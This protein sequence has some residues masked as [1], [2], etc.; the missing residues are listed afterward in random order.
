MNSLQINQPSPEPQAGTSY[1]KSQRD[2]MRQ[3]FN[4]WLKRPTHE[5]CCQALHRMMTDY[6]LAA[7]LRSVIPKPDSPDQSSSN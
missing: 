3:A 5:G 7:R 6:E 1:L 2:D 4:A